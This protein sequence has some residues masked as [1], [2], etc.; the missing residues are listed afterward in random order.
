MLA[1]LHEARGDIFEEIFARSWNL[2]QLGAR[3]VLM[4]MPLF[5]TSA[6]RKGIEV[7]SN[8]SHFALDDALGQLV[9][10]SLV[11]VTDEILVIEDKEQ[12]QHRYNIH[13][14]TRAFAAA[15]LGVEPRIE[16]AARCR[17][18]EHFHQL[19]AKEGGF[20]IQGFF[21]LEP[22]LPNILAIVQWCWNQRQL[23][24]VNMAMDILY[25]IAYLMLSRGYWNDTL[26]L[27]LQAMDLA[28]E[29]DDELR[30]A[31]FAVWPVS[32]VYRHRDDLDRSE[33]YIQEA[34][35]VFDR[36]G[37]EEDITLAK[38]NMGRIAQER[39]QLEG[40]QTLFE[41]A[42]A[43]FESAERT[44]H[45]Y[46]LNVNLA[47]LALGQGNI[48]KAWELTSK[49]IGP[50]RQYGDP[51]IIAGLLSAMGGVTLSR[52]DLEQAEA[53]YEEAL[54]LRKKANRLDETAD[55]LLGLA[56]VQIGLGKSQIAKE[57]LQDAIETYQKLDM[58][59]ARILEIETL[60][61]EA[62]R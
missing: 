31:Q 16:H 13:P 47:H 37:G 9:E 62:S 17:L 42:L 38:R 52:G 44:G 21:L 30:R 33:G 45:A 57:M 15:K 8:T 49:V 55:A 25:D 39:G 24:L 6:S 53:F 12:V 56:R 3:Q 51:E 60:L 4:V 23:Q 11:D 48:E 7:A 14:L 28:S 40:A 35:E 61:D 36:L 58:L 41:E 18:A 19:S 22:E 54:A 59:Q 46:L 20:W 43:Y 27:G 2:L 10:M 1:S 34:M 50:A 26:A 5:E 29:L 32:W